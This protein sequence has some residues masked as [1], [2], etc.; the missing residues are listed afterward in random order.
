MQQGFYIRF[1]YSRGKCVEV[2]HTEKNVC[3][4]LD[5]MLNSIVA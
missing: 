5:G 3:V 2:N 1:N 4:H